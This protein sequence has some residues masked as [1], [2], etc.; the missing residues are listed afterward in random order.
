MFVAALNARTGEATLVVFARDPRFGAHRIPGEAPMPLDERLDV[1]A[2][3]VAVILG[4]LNALKRGDASVRLPV[5]WP[6]TLGRLADA[7]NDVVD[8]N[9]RMAQEL[10]RLSRVVGKEG[11]LGRR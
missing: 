4:A 10:E 6:G 7:F 8:R 2:N 5:A 9:A 3:E 1:N 11:K